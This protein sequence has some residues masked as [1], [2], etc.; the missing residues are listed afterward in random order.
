M[1]LSAGVYDDVTFFIEGQ[2]DIPNDAF[3]YKELSA[4]E[5]LADAKKWI[6]TTLKV[7][8]TSDDVDID[9]WTIDG[10]VETL[11]EVAQDLSA[12]KPSAG[13]IM[14]TVLP[15]GFIVPFETVEKDAERKYVGYGNDWRQTHQSLRAISGSVMRW[16]TRGTGL[17]RKFDLQPAVEVAVNLSGEDIEQSGIRGRIDS[18][19]LEVKKIYPMND[20]DTSILTPGDAQVY[21]ISNE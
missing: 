4:D 5:P 20:E 9:V 15:G 14:S 19:G 11:W 12:A 2:A 3:Y 6:K 13:F 1:N 16:F 7:N 10:G 17:S 18:K 8:E 21:I